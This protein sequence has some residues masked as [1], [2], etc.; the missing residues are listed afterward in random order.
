MNPSLSILL[1]PP[2]FLAACQTAE[3]PKPAPVVAPQQPLTGQAWCA[4]MLGYLGDQRTDPWLKVAILE[5]MKNE[6][7]L[8]TPQAAT[9]VPARPQPARESNPVSF[10]GLSPERQVEVCSFATDLVTGTRTGSSDA[11][12]QAEELIKSGLCRQIP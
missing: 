5:K 6:G 1:I 2:L 8:G 11:L 12:R 7:C 4:Q 3:Q 9:P 10:R